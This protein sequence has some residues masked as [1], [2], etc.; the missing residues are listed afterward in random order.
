MS[1][2]YAMSENRRANDQV[3]QQIE[4]LILSASDPKDKA[5]LLIMNKIAISLDTNTFLTQGLAE[6]F[7]FHT[8]AFKSHERDEAEL[9][10]QGKGGIRVAIALVGIIQ[11]LFGF[12]ITNQ[13]TNIKDIRQELTV[14]TNGVLVHQ[15]QLRVLQGLQK[16]TTP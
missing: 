11:I 7:K 16:S 1:E 13:L 3:Q 8:E 14:V 9:I 10:N 12:I 6:D 2:R 4:D 5:F 15:E